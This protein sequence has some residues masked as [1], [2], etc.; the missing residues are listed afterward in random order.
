MGIHGIY[1]EIGSGL[2]V[3][4]CKLSCEQYT[5]HNRPFR[6]A[7]D[8]SIWLFQIQSGKG[9][10][11]PAIRTFYYRLLRL[12]TLNIHP[13]FVFDGP[14]KPLFKRNKRVG[15]NGAKVVTVPEFLAKQLLES[16]GFPI[17]R[18]PGEAE[19]ECA[20]LQNEGIVDAVLSEDVDTLMFGSGLTLRNWS[21]EG[22]SAKTPTH[23]NV[24]AA[25]DTKRTSGL[26]R[27]G[28]VLVA[29]MSGGDY[30]PEGIPGCGPKLACEAARAGFGAKLCAIRKGDYQA[31]KAW[32]EELVHEIRTNESK[33]FKQKRTALVIPEDFPNLDVLAYYTHPAVSGAEKLQRLRDTLQWDKPLDFAKLRQ[34]ARDAFEWD[35]ISGAKKFIRNMAPAM[36][37]RELRLRGERDS[38]QNDN[39]EKQAAEESALL[40][41]IHGKRNH[42]ITD[43]E[44]EF[45]ISFIPTTL[46]N[47]DLSIEEPDPEMPV[48]EEDD[49]FPAEPPLSQAIED[50]ECPASPKKTRGP[51]QYD[52]TVPEKQW[53]LGMFVR[54][55]APLM[56]Q[57]YEAQFNDPKKFASRNA[58]K[59]TR[60]RKKAAISGG[61]MQC[62]ALDRFVVTRK[63]GVD[64]GQKTNSNDID[65]L[66]L[67]GIQTMAN[68]PHSARSLIKP[69][70]HAQ[71][72]TIKDFAKVTKSSI[73]RGL[74]HKPTET[75]ELDLSRNDVSSSREGAIN[76][77]F[78]STS[79]SSSKIHELDLSKAVQQFRP[80][81]KRA[82]KRP[83]PDLAP[84]PPRKVMK[85]P[86]VIDLSTPSPVRARVSPR[87][88]TPPAQPSLQFATFDSPLPDTVTRR[89]KYTPFKRHLTAP[90]QG[91]DGDMI[92][93]PNQNP[94]I[95]PPDSHNTYAAMDLAGPQPQQKRRLPLQT[96][97]P[98]LDSLDSS[99][100][101]LPSPSMLRASFPKEF[102]AGTASAF[103]ATQG[104][105]T[106]SP[107]RQKPSR[108]I[109][110]W[111]RRSQ[112]ITPGKQQLFVNKVKDTAIVIS[113][114][115]PS[116]PEEEVYSGE[117]SHSHVT[118]E[119]TTA[120]DMA[121]GV[122]VVQR[123]EISMSSLLPAA[124]HLRNR[125][126]DAKTT[127]S[128][129]GS[130]A[131]LLLCAEANRI[132]SQI[133]EV[134]HPRTENIRTTVN[135]QKKRKKYIKPRDSLPGAWKVVEEVDLSTVDHQ[136][137]SASGPTSGP[138]SASVTTVGRGGAGVSDAG[139]RRVFEMSEVEFI[140]LT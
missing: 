19:A 21:A 54:L 95:S 97:Q 70:S 113:S 38:Y 50:D 27:Q 88:V 96:Q 123:T 67:S 40:A 29:M 16:F 132:V 120:P 128:A 114:S 5:K 65:E 133:P 2:R 83:S 85:H 72:H 110:E 99:D 68:Q 6:L 77:S 17:H 49:D 125:P 62:G 112:S 34:F 91:E 90:V 134:S 56:T 130:A 53:I 22:R 46:V 139:Y 41:G 116:P 80:T 140:D 74:S 15:G 89:R 136:L 135:D 33:F 8:I 66:D 12:L 103:I 58:P 86:E 37:I 104:D 121:G 73:S 79:Q 109:H 57:D 137:V 3:A 102:T 117:Q 28:M 107:V 32:K 1:K 93:I 45:R 11:N 10:S 63:A 55:G 82:V 69:I 47:I 24:Y 71:H 9:G 35:C 124:R 20:L 78:A 43:G 111:V 75:N 59:T 98:L 118:D 119:A 31:V 13:I 39:L 87:Q 51:S 129:T 42:T 138:R 76:Q 52:P 122:S 30:I 14:N 92:V 4:L 131:R 23:V 106:K 60:P 127:V 105:E 108:D 100:E 94:Q 7:I 36:L 44:L 101:D 18:A 26:D 84:P 81:A 115:L 25:T 64:R 126:N 61:G 48:D